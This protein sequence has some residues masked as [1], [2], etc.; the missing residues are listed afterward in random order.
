MNGICHEPPG[1]SYLLIPGTARP[2]DF[3]L[4]PG[5]HTRHTSWTRHELRSIC[6]TKSLLV[7]TLHDQSDASS[8]FKN[9]QQRTALAL[10][11]PLPPPLLLPPPPLPP[12]PPPPPP[13]S[14]LLPLLLRLTCSRPAAAAHMHSLSGI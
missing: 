6:Y 12:P 7:S 2:I 13:P 3:T 9:Q 10:L 5:C 8:K 11:L 14:P 1:C 4:Q